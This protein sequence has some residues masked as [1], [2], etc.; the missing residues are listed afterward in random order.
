MVILADRFSL[1]DDPQPNG[2]VGATA[3]TVFTPFAALY[4]ASWWRRQRGWFFGDGEEE[5]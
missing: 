3:V 1:R 2:W 4:W 5:T